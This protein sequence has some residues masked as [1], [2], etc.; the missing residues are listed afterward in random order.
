[1]ARPVEIIPETCRVRRLVVTIPTEPGAMQQAFERFA[2]FRAKMGAETLQSSS[3]QYSFETP[4]R[5]VTWEFHTEFITITWRAA[6]NDSENW[7]ADMGL[8]AIA[9]GHLIAAARVDAIE[10][11]VTPDRLLGGFNLASLCLADVENGKAQLAT[12]F[13]PD[14]ARFTRLEFAAGGLTTL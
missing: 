9:D 5:A 14:A 8:A 6:S 12:D 4:E 2:Q 13:V 3:R 1:H 11:S 10:D 7:P